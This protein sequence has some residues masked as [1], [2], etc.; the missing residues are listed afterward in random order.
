MNVFIASINNDIAEFTHEESWHCAK[1][2]R[3]K[4]G[5]EVDLIDGKGNFF[6]GELYTVNEKKCVAKIKATLKPQPKRNYY[7]HLAI[8]PTK[9]IDRIEWLLGKDAQI[10]I[11]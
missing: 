6:K 11:D 7:L 8:A 5:D 3:F 9:Q 10:G 4:A 2:L 1:V